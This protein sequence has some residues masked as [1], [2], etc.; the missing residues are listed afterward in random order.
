MKILGLNT[1]KS[2][3][4]ARKNPRNFFGLGQSARSGSWHDP[5]TL[6]GRSTGRS[7]VRRLFVRDPYNKNSTA[8]QATFS[9]VADEFSHA[10]QTNPK[11]DPSRAPGGVAK[12]DGTPPPPRGAD[13]GHSKVFRPNRQTLFSG[14]TL[15][16]RR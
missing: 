16:K 11:Y 3:A 15:K 10:G 1:N 5:E 6:T 9:P 13:S 12:K 14:K 2:T 8:T 7:A 4:V